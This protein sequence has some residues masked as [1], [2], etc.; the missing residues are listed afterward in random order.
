MGEVD[1]VRLGLGELQEGLFAGGVWGAIGKG[2]DRLGAPESWAAWGVEVGV[3]E[4]R[5]P[6]LSGQE[7]LPAM[8]IARGVEDLGPHPSKSEGRGV[9]GEEI[10][11]KQLVAKEDCNLND[12]GLQIQK[13]SR[14]QP[15]PLASEA[16][17]CIP[18]AA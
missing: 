2:K 13:R 16:P 14:L 5:L 18:Q 4:A 11:K 12:V 8:I 3:E 7:G 9:F 15:C 17:E 6:A 10:I 1:R